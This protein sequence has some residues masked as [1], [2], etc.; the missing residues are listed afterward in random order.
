MN[1]MAALDWFFQLITNC[2]SWLGSVQL[3]AGLSL[4]H[5]LLGF[6]LLGAVMAV[7]VPRA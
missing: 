5:I 6:T 1:V 3:V 7:L 2:V 4:L